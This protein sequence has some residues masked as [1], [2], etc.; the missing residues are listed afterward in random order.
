MIAQ[1]P[2]TIDYIGGIPMSWFREI[3]IACD[4]FFIRRGLP[5]IE[6]TFRDAITEDCQIKKAAKNEK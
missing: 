5:L 6:R 4:Q 2:N 3:D 1:A